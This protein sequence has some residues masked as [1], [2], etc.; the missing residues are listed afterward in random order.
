MTVTLLPSLPLESAPGNTLAAA[1][2]YL[3]RALAPIPIPLN[4]KVPAIARWPELVLSESDLPKYFSAPGNIGI[5]LGEPS[6]GLVDVDID[7]DIALALAAEFLPPTGMRHG[8]PSRPGSHFWYRV[9]DTLRSAR[10]ADPDGAVVVEIRSTGA[11]T[12]VPPSMH[13][14][15]E[16]YEWECLDEPAMMNSPIAYAPPDPRQ[17]SSRR[18]RRLPACPP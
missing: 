3:R 6:G 16:P 12:V 1:S 15:G 14:A 9:T 5:L 2:D 4:S 17:K 8:R 7:D 10:F 11:Q 18:A 13:P